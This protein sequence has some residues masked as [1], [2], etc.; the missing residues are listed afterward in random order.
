MKESTVIAYSYAKSVLARDFPGNRFFEKARVH[1]HCPEGAVQKDG[2][3]CL[4]LPS[5]NL[6]C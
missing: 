3:F 4:L 5:S 6:A 2:M 1:L